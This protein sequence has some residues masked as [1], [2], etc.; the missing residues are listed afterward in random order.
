ML[1]QASIRFTLLCH[2]ARQ[3][4]TVIVAAARSH[5]SQNSDAGG[6]HAARSA[7]P[8]GVT[9]DSNLVRATNPAIFGRKPSNAVIG[10]A[11][12]W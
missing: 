8:A 7:P 12:P 9:S 6:H 4:P 11:A 10:E 1:E 3:L 5:S 2:K